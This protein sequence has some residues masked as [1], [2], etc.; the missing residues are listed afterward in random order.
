MKQVIQSTKNGKLELRRVP[1]PKI[2][3]GHI[4]VATRA[5]LISAGTER[6][7]I[8][9]AKQSLAGKARARPDL[10]RKVIGKA[11]RDGLAA[12]FRSVRARLD[13]PLALGYSAA[14][15]VIEVG[16]GL[17][18]RFGVGEKVAVAGAGLANHAEINLIPGNL[19]AVIPA[20]V[21]YDQA[22]F[23]T[24]GAIALHAVHN[25]AGGGAIGLGD[26]VAV[27][28]VGLV[29]Q[30]AAQFLTLSGARVMVMDYDPARLD[31]ALALGAEEAV[32]LSAGDGGRKVAAWT[33]GRGVDGVLI[34]AATDSAEPFETAA[35]IARDRA[36]VCMVGLTGTAFPYQTFMKKELNVIVSRSYGPGR[37]DADFEDKGVKYPVGWVRWTETA[38]L[39]ETLRLLGPGAARRLDVTSLTSHRFSID[40]AEAAYAKV[41]GDEPCLGVVL[42]YGEWQGKS[43]PVPAFAAAKSAPKSAP[44]FAPKFALKSAPSDKCVLGVIGAGAFARAVLLPELRRLSQVELH[45]I[46][47]T[48]GA[49]AEH[50]AGTFGFR[51]AAADSSLVLANPEINAVLIATRHDSHAELTARALEAGKSVLVEKPLGLSHEELTR[52]AAAREGSAGF[53]QIGFNRR[54]A[55]MAVKIR[56][57][58]AAV[59]GPKFVVLRINAGAVAGDSWVNDPDKGGGRVLGEMCHFV[60]LARF[61]IGRP[62]RFV[63]A[64]AAKASGAAADD[65]SAMLR[66]ADGSLATIAY[67]GLGDAALGKE[68][69]EA[70]GGGEAIR[71]DNFMQLT[72]AA[73]GKSRTKKASRQDKGFAAALRAFTDAVI[74]GGPAPVPEDELMETST[75]TIAVLESLGSGRRVDL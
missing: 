24:L 48:K 44:K 9:F 41:T 60:D 23:A 36:R 69:V 72:I 51:S 49:D 42:D 47:T 5:S 62:I 63:H 7:V 59:T 56:D 33:G 32:N 66:F 68:L 19:A 39:A 2:K 35:A 34:A 75:A 57:L 73:G 21:P 64:D 31:L 8:R 52:V 50:V 55:P 46:V 18:G 70:Y 40:Q 58:L 25:L 38:N 61:F 4:L 65:V 37:Y 10:V 26:C 11:K 30:L 12:T 20:G 71:M 16:R 1:A 53:F 13:S 3:D 43:K 28:G 15:E 29:G 74:A 54:Y 6:M 45:T 27:I 14:G 17:E 22:C 67:T